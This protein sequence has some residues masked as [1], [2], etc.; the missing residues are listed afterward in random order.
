M[1]ILKKTF[2]KEKHVENNTGG[3]P[4]T[5]NFYN[6]MDRII[7]K[8]PKVNGLIQG[9][10]GKLWV[11]LNSSTTEKVI[12]E[13]GKSHEEDS[14]MYMEYIDEEKAQRETLLNKKGIE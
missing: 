5:W 8:T 7:G 6:D 14:S 13:M 1:N 10:N 9:Y 11:N 2:K 4:S 12:E 3:T